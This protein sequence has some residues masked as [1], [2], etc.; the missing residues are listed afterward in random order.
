MSTKSETIQ[1]AAEAPTS[2]NRS[3]APFKL[4]IVDD[5]DDV[6][7]ATKQVLRPY[8]TA[9]SAPIFLHAYNSIDAHQLLTANRDI[10]VILLDVVMETTDAGLTLINT[11]RSDLQLSRTQIILRTGQPGHAREDAV[12]T[13]YA[14]NGYL[15]KSS[16]TPASLFSAITTA[17]RTYSLLCKEALMSAALEALLSTTVEHVGDQSLDGFTLDSMAHM[18]AMF[19]TPNS[20][21]VLRRSRPDQPMTVTTTTPEFSNLSGL[22]LE[23][24]GDKAL[25]ERIESCLQ[26]KESII[27]NQAATLFFPST[28]SATSVMHVP[29]ET[30]SGPR[31]PVDEQ[32][33]GLMMTTY[34]SVSDKLAR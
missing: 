34:A 12:V 23:S 28:H 26:T 21:L 16:L 10:A 30:K 9:Q 4:L 13:E 7:I 5:D 8:Y 19:E 14:I 6:H 1:F 15:N 17:H 27:D 25:R 22:R 33:L 24:I 11:I 20:G 29:R 32:L 18:A 3:S 31:G 2:R